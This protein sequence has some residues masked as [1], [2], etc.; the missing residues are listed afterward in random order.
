MTN[1]EVRDLL[2]AAENSEVLGEHI[3]IHADAH[4]NSEVKA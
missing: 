4:I 3:D 1:L 2:F